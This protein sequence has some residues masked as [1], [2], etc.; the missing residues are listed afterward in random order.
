MSG[1]VAS[2]RIAHGT[3]RIAHADR[4]VTAV[5]GRS[6]PAAVAVADLVIVES[7]PPGRAAE[8]WAAIRE[9]WSQLTFYLLDANSWR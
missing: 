6:W 7:P 8:R 3:P 4:T 2:A 9:R 1:D 5:D